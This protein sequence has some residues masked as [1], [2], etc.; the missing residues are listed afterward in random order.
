LPKKD[1]AMNDESNR[2][3]IKSIERLAKAVESINEKILGIIFLCAGFVMGK[4]TLT[5]DILGLIF[6]F[7]TGSF[8]AY[9]IINSNRPRL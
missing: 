7:I 2:E 5:G 6:S 4:Y 1:I 3:L 8:G 9:I